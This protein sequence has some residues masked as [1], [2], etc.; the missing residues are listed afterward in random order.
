MSEEEKIEDHFWKSFELYQSLVQTVIKFNKDGLPED[1]ILNSVTD[2]YFNT[3]LSTNVDTATLKYVTDE[4]IQRHARKKDE[5][6][7]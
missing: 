4:M 3:M 6:N 2:L 5:M 7:D 1:A